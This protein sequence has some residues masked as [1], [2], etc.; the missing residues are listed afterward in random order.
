M[1]VKFFIFTTSLSMHNPAEKKVIGPKN[2]AIL[3]QVRGTLGIL[4]QTTNLTGP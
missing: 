2:R 4:Q 1:V 3:P